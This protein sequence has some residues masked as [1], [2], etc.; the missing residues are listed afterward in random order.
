MQLSDIRT[1]ARYHISPQ[2]TSTQYPDA[3]LDRNANHWYKKIVG[4]AI[5][6]QGDWQMGGEAIYRDFQPGVSTYAL[7]DRLVRVFKG[8]VMY[9]TGGSFVPLYFRDIQA[10]QGDVE[11]NASRDFD[12]TDRPTADLI[13]TNIQIRPTIE[14]GGDTVVNGIKLWVQLSLSDMDA[15][16]SIPELMEPVQ[17]ALSIGAA[18]DYAEAEEMWTKYRE[19]K[20]QMFGDPRVKDDEGIRGELRTLYSIRSGAKR[21]GMN[22]RRRSYK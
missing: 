21:D 13:G 15:S 16:N 9:E 18:M 12:D 1:D 8:E 7:P 5:A 10:N 17:R 14:A 20:Y 19:L 2:L 3:D 11:G 22:A 6:T 4:W